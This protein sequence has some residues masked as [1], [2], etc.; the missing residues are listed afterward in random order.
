MSRRVLPLCAVALIQC[1]VLLGT[2]E[3]DHRPDASTG[4]G[5]DAAV[6]P[7][8]SA[9]LDSSGDVGPFDGGTEATGPRDGSAADACTPDLS[10]DPS[11][12]GV[13]GRSCL[14]SSC[15]NG[16]CDPLLLAGS[17]DTDRG[18]GQLYGLVDIGG[19]LYG[20]DW[21]APLAL[22][23]TVPS[24]GSFT[25]PAP[26][27]PNPMTSDGGADGPANVLA[28]D[29]DNSTLYFGMYA[30]ETA[31]PQPGVWKSD[32]Q[33]NASYFA[34]TAGVEALTVDTT[35]VYWTDYNAG[36]HVAT[37]DGTQVAN[38]ATGATIPYALAA[39][40][41]IYFAQN[42]LL[43]FG[44]P[45]AAS[46]ATPL[47]TT[48]V[49]AFAVD[50]GY[51]YWLDTSNDLYRRHADGSGAPAKGTPASGIP[52]LSG[53]KQHLLVDDTYVYIN[54]TVYTQ[55]V[56]GAIIRIRKDFSGGPAEVMLRTTG[57]GFG[58]VTQD[59]AAL[60]YG[61]YS[62]DTVAPFTAIWKLAK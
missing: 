55:P 32:L 27:F 28:A 12:C 41:R 18:L 57:Y 50:S 59:D 29:P 47:S 49:A 36:L 39:N 42:N 54:S 35:Y 6:V 22:L 1:N 21:Y 9:S 13:C 17:P 10:S 40:S 7:D 5:L 8:G 44:T 58:A 48:P 26:L 52:L 2:P 46:D 24:S 23:Y 16:E 15:T 25:V 45:P 30:Q 61:T 62:S 53:S 31:W 43:V 51:A 56:A 14:T 60:Y 38:I 33:G 20:T 3:P 11:N 19:W 4:G 34:G 37:K